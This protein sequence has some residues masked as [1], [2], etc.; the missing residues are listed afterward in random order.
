MSQNDGSGNGGKSQKR[1]RSHHEA[2]RGKKL[3]KLS[4]LS[5]ELP[6]EHDQETFLEMLS[7]EPSDRS[8]AIMAAGLVEQA[9]YEAIKCRLA[10]PGES[11]LRDW[12]D[13]PNAPFGTFAAKIKLGRGLAVYGPK[14][15]SKLGLIKD[16]RNV[17]AHRSTHI[18][19][20]NPTIANEVK[21]FLDK[22][23]KQGVRI[24]AIYSAVCLATAKLLIDDAF[25]NGGKEIEVSFP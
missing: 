5:R 14:M 20:A 24:R 1:D 15:E 25:K 2:A 12:F 10:D 16:I 7:A 13:A 9:L 4:D 8:A 23:A 21:K 17:F 22:P 18:D 3:P 11:G 19:F 6:S